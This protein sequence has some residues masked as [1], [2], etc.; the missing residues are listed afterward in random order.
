[1]S[2]P[3]VHE[4]RVRWGE[5]DPQG[6]VF[7]ANYVAYFDDAIGALWRT[8]FGSYAAMTERGLDMVVAELN[9]NYRGS[10]RPEET[11]R[12]EVSIERFGETSLSTRLDVLRDDELL[13]EGR[14][15]HVF[16]DTTT[17]KKSPIP[18]WVREALAP[19][20]P[21]E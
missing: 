21:Q 18:P 11:I 7:N 17:W 2:A 9:V 13:V 10:A 14:I 15:R 12:I 20:G 16:L 1:V 3:F 8:A 19:Y 6:I 4:I 5:C